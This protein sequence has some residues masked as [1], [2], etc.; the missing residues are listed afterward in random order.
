MNELEYL[1]LAIG[2]PFNVAVV[3]RINGKISKNLVEKLMTKL[4][5]RHPLLQVRLIFDDN[6][7]PYSTSKNVGKIPVTE[8][9]RVDDSQAMKEFHRQLTT[10]FDLSN[11]KLLLIRVVLYSSTEK[12][13]LVVCSYHTIS[14]GYSM[15][16]LTKDLLKFMANP[17]MSIE[18]IDFPTKDVDLFTPKVRKMIPKR[19]FFAHLLHIALRLYN[20]FRY[21]FVG[22]IKTAKINV[23]KDDLEIHSTKLSK[24]QSA[25]FLEKCKTENI[26][27]HSAVSTVFIHEHPI[28]ASPVNIRK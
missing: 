27:V 24:E 5:K 15:L 13:D 6:N 28:I 22:K 14:D 18:V 8:Y 21:L 20:F 9:K 11:N 2:Q 16:F 1:S 26:S 10:P 23:H 25:K 7:R 19:P 17:D 3:L 12:S 4:Q